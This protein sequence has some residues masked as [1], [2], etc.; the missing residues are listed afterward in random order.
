MRPR[1]PKARSREA[2]HEALGRHGQDR[3]RSAMRGPEP[4]PGDLYTLAKTADFPLEWLVVERARDLCRLV[5]ADTHPGLESADVAV[6]AGTEGG[7][8]S[9]RCASSVQV[10]VETLRREERTGTVA[11]EILE[12]V[13]RRMEELAAGSPDPSLDEPDAALEDWRAEVLVPALA[14]LRP[15]PKV[16]EPPRRAGLRLAVAASLIL[17]LGALGGLSLLSWRLH[18]GEL[19]ARGEVE[20]LNQENRELLAEHRRQLEALRKAQAPPPVRPPAPPPVVREP[21]LPIVNLAYASFF[22]GETRGATQEIV[23]SARARNLLLQFYVGDAE[24]CQKIELE[25]EG[26]G[27]PAASSTVKGLR[28]LPGQQEVN[29]AISRKQLPNGVYQFRLSGECQ[30]ERRELSSYEA[31]LKEDSR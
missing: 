19:E 23:I 7:P 25:I 16:E 22:P 29:V 27:A 24:T 10:G 26:R 11:P 9:V 4:W 12:A 28:P 14:A 15:G 17:L 2:L 8:L 21:L 13:R 6:P 31:L 1:D 5:A 20:R 3:A 30:G 18:R